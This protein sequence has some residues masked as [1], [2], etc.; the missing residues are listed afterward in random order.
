MHAEVVEQSESKSS[1]DF[2]SRTL[3]RLS[4]SSNFR[5]YTQFDRHKL[6]MYEF[7]SLRNDNYKGSIFITILKGKSYVTIL[8]PKLVPLHWMKVVPGIIDIV[9][10]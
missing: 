4:Y 6:S 3:V 8:T 9:I 7:V 2:T 10:H 5:V 1:L